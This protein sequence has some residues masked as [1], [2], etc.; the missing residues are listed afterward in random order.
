MHCGKRGFSSVLLGTLLMTSMLS[1]LHGGPV[2]SAALAQENCVRA[3]IADAWT[4]A[5]TADPH[6]R[7]TSGEAV[8]IVN[9]V[10]ERLID[11]DPD[12]NLTPKLAESWD[13]NADATEWTIKLRPGVKFHDGQELTADDVVYSFRRLNEH[14]NAFPAV[15][16]LPSLTMDGITA[17]DPQTVVFTTAKPTPELPLLTSIF[18]G[19]IVPEGATAESMR[20]TANGTGPYTLESYAPG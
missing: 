5:G 11:L 4:Q 7:A 15:N 12:F 10:Y 1:G 18:E 17:K 16:Q 6:A 13:H 8:Y 9:N 20:S 19:V 2:P 14:E 3:G